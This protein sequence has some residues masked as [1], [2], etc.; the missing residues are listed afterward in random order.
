MPK[1]NDEIFNNLELLEEYAHV[2]PNKAF[3]IIQSVVNNK[4]PLKAKATYLKGFGKLYGKSYEDLLVQGIKILSKIRYLETNKVIKLL[5]RLH[6][7]DTNTVKSEALKAFENVSQYNLFVL[8]QIEYKTQ[9]LILDE[10]NGWSDA[11]IIK[12]LEI[13][14]VVAKELLSPT[15]EGQSMPDYK[16]FTFHSGPLVVSDN[17]KSIRK[18]TISLLKRIYSLA[19]DLPQK[20]K[21]LQNLQ[22]ATQT[23]HSHLYGDDMK[24]MVLDDTNDIIGFYLEILPKAENEIIQDIEEQKIWFT[25]RFKKE[26]PTKLI[27]LEE[28]IQSNSAYSVFRVFVGYDGRLDPDY[29]FNRDKETRSQKINEFISDISEAN[30]EEW[31]QR[32]LTVVKNYS[33]AELGSYGYFET[34]LSELGDKKPNLGILLIE[35]NE[36]EIAPFLISLLSGIWKSDTKKAKEIISKWVDEGKYL[37]TWAFIFVVVGDLDEKL[38]RKIFDKAKEL[39]DIRALNNIL[40]STL[41]HYPKHKNLKPVFIEIINEL[42]KH[43]DTWWVENL[44]FKGESILSELTEK[45]LDVILDGLLLLPNI[46]YRG[47]EI[48]KPVAEK[49][50]EK[51]IA[52]F[53]KR[54]EIKS[55]KKRG[56]D[57]R[58][59]GVPFNFY[60]LGEVLKKHE[61]VIVPI[62]LKWYGDGGNKHNWLFRW[63]ASHL[64]EEIFPGFSP[65]LEQSLIDL[66]KKASKNS[67]S[68]VF[69]VLGKYKGGQ[70]LWSVVKALVQQY[71]STKEYE[72]VQ[73]HLFGYLS[74]TGVVSGEDGF[75]RAYQAKKQEIQDLKKDPNKQVR[76]FAKEYDDYLDRRITDETKRT[77]EQ[78]ELMKR[79]LG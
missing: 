34:F 14:F 37:H 35:K 75:V 41:H 15:F 36:K 72:E 57:D 48:L 7:H 25:R 19:K 13:L 55:K 61:K 32:I 29:D 39:K 10:I 60:K 70:F 68:I 6:Q 45:E 63:E 71:A 53:H 31:R 56:I 76:K 8:Q 51:V 66:V 54:V 17:L 65:V 73:G 69:S 67:R 42:A 28:A 77:N 64:F 46:E 44:W 26:P 20:T 23:P 5:E 30:F 52:F 16:T 58:Y 9:N 11:K 22:E 21:T 79:G 74:Q 18:S 40:R 47:E 38:F 1:T 62:L 33:A 43:K 3:R 2:T 59:D 49:Y 78:I 24:Q 50:P 12:N 27:E 4:H